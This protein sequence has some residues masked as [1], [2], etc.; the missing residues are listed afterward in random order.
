MVLDPESISHIDFEPLALFYRRNFFKACK[1]GLS[2]LKQDTGFAK[3]PAK[4]F[5]KAAELA[6][7]RLCTNELFLL[8]VCAFEDLKCLGKAALAVGVLKRSL[9]L[10]SAILLRFSGLWL[11]FGSFILSF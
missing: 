7:Q 9:R 5:G 2:G 1:L 8:D 11:L 4:I 6:K 10:R 3:H